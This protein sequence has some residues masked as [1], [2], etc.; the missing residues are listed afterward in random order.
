MESILFA[1]YST[2][3]FV[4]NQMNMKMIMSLPVTDIQYYS[5]TISRHNKK[6]HRIYTWMYGNNKVINTIHN[7]NCFI[8]NFG[9]DKNINEKYKLMDKIKSHNLVHASC[10]YSAHSILNIISGYALVY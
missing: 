4:S 8:K 6:P 5:Q 2:S 10:D 3:S 7:W 9:S 1:E